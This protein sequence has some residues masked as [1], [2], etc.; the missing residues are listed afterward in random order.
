MKFA[1]SL[2]VLLLLSQCSAFAQSAVTV[3]VDP[4]S[5]GAAIPGDYCGLSFGTIVLKKGTHGYL[6]DTT[7]T[8]MLTLF[9]QLGI[10]HLR[11]G[12]TAVD[13][14]K[15]GFEPGKQDVDALFRFAKAAGVNVVYSLRLENGDTAYD[16][17]M[18]TYVWDNYRK[19]LDCFAIG[20]EPDI[21]RGGDPEISGYPSYHGKWKRFAEA[22]LRSVPAAKL[23]GPDATSNS[24]W[25]TNF[26]RDEAGSGYVTSIFAHYYVGGGS[27]KKTG[28]QLIDEMLSP[29]WPA[30]NYPDRL[31]VTGVTASQLGLAYRFTEANS[32][33]GN[34]VVGGSNSF[35]TA[36]FSLDFLHWWAAHGCRGIDLHC[37]MARLN[38]TIYAGQKGDYQIFPIGYGVSAFG[39]GGRGNSFPVETING[40]SLNL[41]CYATGGVGNMY[42]TV[43]NKEHSAG[44]RDANVSISAAGLPRY[45]AVIYLNSLNGESGPSSEVRLGGATINNHGTFEG[46]WER[47]SDAATGQIT[48]NVPA[49]SAAIVRFSEQPGTAETR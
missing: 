31:K 39:I 32:Y 26:A 11:I 41:T 34:G 10:K 7:N 15:S 37:T 5:P 17:S 2:F 47:I 19:Y 25:E 22:T 28:Q 16:A 33:Y 29:S 18:A 40:D 8:Q 44:A 45:A 36:L 21:Y 49:M 14:N 20:N 12:G 35:A 27:D 3:I 4:K 46:R 24:P 23:G 38:T 9:R 48:V 6:F 30:S 13:T 43:V 42:V 1:A